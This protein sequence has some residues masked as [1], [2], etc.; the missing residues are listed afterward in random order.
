[1]EKIAQKKHQLDQAGSLSQDL[2]KN[3]DEWFRVE[4][5]YTSN[6][7]EGNTLS[8]QETALVIEKGLTVEGKSIEE[9]LEAKNHAEVLD[10]VKNLL[11]EKRKRQDILEGD[12]LNIH[13]IILQHLDD[14]NAG[15]YRSVS[16][17]IAGS[18]A[19][20]PNP[21]EVPELMGELM[22]WL[23]GKN[24][25]D[26]VKIGADAHFKLVTIHPFTDGNG[27]TA[28]ILMNILLRQEGYPPAIIQNEDRRA[29]LNSLEKG[30]TKGEL[31][32]YY[33]LI[34]DAVERSLDIY[35]DAIGK[36]N[37]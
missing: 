17:R 22:Q 11:K 36:S 3:L 37:Q 20:M 5:T 35:L 13:R 19:V 32:D 14:K 28:R 23:H 2:V 9:H 21:M 18:T 12:I 6:A 33:M 31:G 15:K 16:V 8:R 29:Y 26:P 27:R 4:L 30:Q 24:S 25:D 34:Y 1:M 7:I 10:F